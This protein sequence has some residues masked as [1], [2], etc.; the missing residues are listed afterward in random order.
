[1]RGAALADRAAMIVA[2]CG[3]IGLAGRGAGTLAALGA[4]PVHLILLRLPPGGHALAVACLV[5]AAGL[6]AHRAA[7]ILHDPDP[8]RVVADEAAGAL[9][10]LLVVA[11]CG[12]WAA[13]AAFLL[14]RIL[15][16]AKPWP[17]RALEHRGPAGVAIMADDIAAAFAAGAAVRLAAS[18]RVFGG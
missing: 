15:D 2:T 11:E 3:G 18:L 14:F 9:L 7:R 5:L 4:V 10:A 8:Q 17:I 16:I 12:F 1:M 13:G 6:A